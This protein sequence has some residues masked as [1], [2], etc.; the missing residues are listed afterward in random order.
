MST[1]SKMITDACRLC[2]MYIEQ[3]SNDPSTYGKDAQEALAPI[4]Q[5]ALK[6]SQ[7]QELTGREKPTVIT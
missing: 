7:L 4:I 5:I 2:R 6:L 1:E 3:Y